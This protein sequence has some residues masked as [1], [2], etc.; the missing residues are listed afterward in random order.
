MCFIWRT[1]DQV[2]GRLVIVHSRAGP[3]GPGEFEGHGE[4]PLRL[5]I[6]K[7]GQVLGREVS[8]ALYTHGVYS[9]LVLITVS[10][11]SNWHKKS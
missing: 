2:R 9:A 1:P 4:I 10:K 5:D 8:L 7:P 3:E 11:V 6:K